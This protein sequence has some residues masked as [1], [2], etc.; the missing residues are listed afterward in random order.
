MCWEHVVGVFGLV[1]PAFVGLGLVV[2]VMLLPPTVVEL[3]KEQM[4]MSVMC[5][6]MI[7]QVHHE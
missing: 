5:V 3:W 7:R 4:V 1:C 6:L 2:V